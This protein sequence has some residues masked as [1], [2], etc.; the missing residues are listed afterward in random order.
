MAT[1][2][3]VSMEQLPHDL[4]RAQFTCQAVVEAPAGSRVKVYY[5]PDSHRFRIGKFLPLGMV[6]PLDFAFVPSTLAGDGDPVDVLILPEASL[7]VGSIVKVRI[8]G[9]LEAEQF[10]ANKRPRRND[11]IIARLVESRLFAKV[12]QL[13]QM[14][15][16]FIEELKTFFETYK[17]LRGQTYRILAVGDRQRAVELIDEGALVYCEKAT[18]A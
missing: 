18:A 16:Q 8:L 10:K 17:R 12:Q 14:G 7:P 11:R 2:T 13:D 1:K 6:F 9:V 3:P 5:D 4:D 15:D